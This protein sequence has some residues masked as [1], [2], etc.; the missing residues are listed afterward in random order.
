MDTDEIKQGIKELQ[1]LY[2]SETMRLSGDKRKLQMA[3]NNLNRMSE[4]DWKLFADTG[5]LP[6]K[7]KTT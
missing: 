6:E 2:N 5:Q 1:D 4:Q 3:L 7:I